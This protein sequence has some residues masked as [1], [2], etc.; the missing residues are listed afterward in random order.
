MNKRG[1]IGGAAPYGV[2]NPVKKG[3]F[4]RARP[5]A[6]AKVAK[7]KLK[8][9]WLK[10]LFFSALFI[11]VFALDFFSGDDYWIVSA[12]ILGL[13]GLFHLLAS[14]WGTKILVGL[15]PLV[16]AIASL[17]FLIDVPF[18]N[19]FAS[20]MI[21]SIILAVVFIYYLVFGAK[22]EGIAGYG[23]MGGRAGRVGKGVGR[24]V[25]AAGAYAGGKIKKTFGVFNFI[26]FILIVGGSWILENYLDVLG[27]VVTGV[28]LLIIGLLLLF[29]K[30]F[31]SK[32]LAIISLVLVIPD[33]A[34]YV[35]GMEGFLD[36]ILVGDYIGP[37]SW[38]RYVLI[39]IIAFYWIFKKRK[40]AR[41]QA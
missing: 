15:V 2:A 7:N 12:I 11:I 10:T 5:A 26:M 40:W 36:L 29:R 13:V 28:I 31:V 41:Q 8:R 17:P 9:N 19:W 20:G 27:G 1:Q 6:Y 18:I 23:Q 34:L 33:I 39:A 22:K 25:G 35:P 3:L 14:K 30:G 38:I 32:L 16:L 4:G 37:S 21:R 24:G